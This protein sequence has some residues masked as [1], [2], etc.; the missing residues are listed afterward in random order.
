MWRKNIFLLWSAA[1]VDLLFCGDSNTHSWIIA[2]VMLCGLSLD[3]LFCL[4]YKDVSFDYLG[5][6]R[7]NPIDLNFWISF[8]QVKSSFSSS[9]CK[10]ICI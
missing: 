7:I 6:N 3:E 1:Y 9:L 2:S 8:V 4:L 5:W 10:V